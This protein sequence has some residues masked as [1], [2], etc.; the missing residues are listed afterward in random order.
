MIKKQKRTKR[1]LAQSLGLSRASLCYISKQLPK[2]W[3]LKER[4]IP[5]LRD[6]PSYGFR[7][8]ALELR[9]N[10][11]RAQRVMKL[12]GMKACRRR[13]KRPRKTGLA[14]ILYLST[15]MDLFAR[16]IAGWAV[17]NTHSVPLVL[18]ALFSAAEHHP[19]PN[20]FHSDN[21]R[22]YG[23]RIFTG[24]LLGFGIRIS[25]SKKSSPWENGYQ[26]SFYSQFKADLG[27]PERFKSLGELVYEI[28]RLVWD[29]NH[30]RIHSALKMP[31]ALFSN[32]YQKL[33][34]KV[35]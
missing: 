14:S 24:A 7:R 34:K 35:S 32:R 6:R 15:V 28:H 11:K 20:I 12:F 8:V 2:D 26:E 18:Q 19:R 23:S 29:Y 27:D 30:R 13:G 22:E 16:E 3:S 25:R 17:M 10:K 21:G 1:E 4:I 33:V 9:I 31:P 5:V